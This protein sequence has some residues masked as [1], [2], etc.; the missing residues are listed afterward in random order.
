MRCWL[1]L[2]LS[3]L[4]VSSLLSEPAVAVAVAVIGTADVAG[5]NCSTMVHCA[6]Q[7]V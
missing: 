3:P 6:I 4:L 5:M 7:H 2:L 1:L